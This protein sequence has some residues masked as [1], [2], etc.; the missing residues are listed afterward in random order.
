MSDAL[1]DPQQRALAAYLAAAE[2]ALLVLGAYARLALQSSPAT[3]PVLLGIIRKIDTFSATCNETFSTYALPVIFRD[4]RLPVADELNRLV[5]ALENVR[6]PEREP[7]A[8]VAAAK[9]ALT[10]LRL[11]V[12]A[13]E[14][15]IQGLQPLLHLPAEAPL[16]E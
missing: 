9:S 15:A 16:P 6:L 10:D 3:T 12:N 2:E 1:S 5:A 13:L 8:Q 7:D 4:R 11:A 14:H